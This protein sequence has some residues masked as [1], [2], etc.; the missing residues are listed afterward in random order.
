[1]LTPLKKKKKRALQ[2]KSKE[3]N[4]VR[5]NRLDK[6][7]SKTVVEVEEGLEVTLITSLE[8]LMEDSSREDMDKKKKP[9]RVKMLREL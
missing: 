7:Y 1:M 3:L 6:N 2:E 9:G 4:S 8:D 5:K